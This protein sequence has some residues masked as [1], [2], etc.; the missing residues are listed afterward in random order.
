MENLRKLGDC[1]GGQPWAGEQWCKLYPSKLGA[2]VVTYIHPG[3]H[4]FPAGASAT[5][6]KFFKEHALP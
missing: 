4:N 2:P 1:G 3:Q 5:I 6:V